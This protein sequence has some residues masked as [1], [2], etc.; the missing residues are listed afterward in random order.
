MKSIADG[1]PPDVARQIYADWRKNE[2]DYW[3][4]R[5]SLLTEY[6]NQWIAFAEGAVIFSGSSPV[7]VFHRVQQ[8]GKHPYVTCVGREDEPC[9]MRR[10]TFA[11]DRSSV[12][13]K[14]H[15]NSRLTRH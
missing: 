11:Y 3:A 2:A 14:H 1:L 12:N 10:A 5:D 6:A 8:S 7:E 15:L 9:R 4:A 13:A